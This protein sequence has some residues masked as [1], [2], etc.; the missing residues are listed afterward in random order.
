MKKQVQK[1]VFKTGKKTG[2]GGFGWGGFMLDSD[3][4]V[5]WGEGSKGANVRGLKGSKGGGVGS[6]ESF[7]N[8]R[9]GFEMQ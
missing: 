7:C 6:T 3:G 8:L 9:L 5:Q 1:T 2:G 4:E